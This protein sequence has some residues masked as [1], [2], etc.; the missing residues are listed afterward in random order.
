MTSFVPLPQDS[1]TES[2]NQSLEEQRAELVESL[3]TIIEQG[4]GMD[5]AEAIA[6]TE[7]LQEI[8]R[9]I[10][11]QE[12]AA[13]LTADLSTFMR[14]SW[15]IVE[16][17]TPLV[18]NWHY[19][20]MC[21][22]LTLVSS[23]EFK[24]RH[25]EKLGII[26]NVPPRTGKSTFSSVIWPV[27]TWLQ[28][29]ARRFL[30]ASHS[31]TLAENH[32]NKRAWLLKSLYFKER[33]ADRFKLVTCAGD[34]IRNDKTGQ[35]HVTSVGAG[36][37]G[38]GGMILVGDDL[39]DREKAFSK[40][41]KAKAN[42]WI[43][44]SFSK[45]LDDQVRGVT[46]HISQ[47]LAVDDPTGHLLGEDKRTG[48]PDHWIRIKIAREAVE[49]ELYVF[50]ISGQRYVRPKGDILQGKD[51]CPPLV[52]TRLKSKAREWANQEQQEPTPDTGAIINPNWMR[53]YRAGDTLP[54]FFRVIESIDCTFKAGDGTDMVAIHKYGLT[55]K[56][57]VLLDRR[58]ER[59]NYPS[60]KQAA[61]EMG[62]GGQKVGWLKDPMPPANLLLVENKA[63][64]PAL[65]DELRDDPEFSLTIIEYEPG[66]SSKTE[67]F[68][69]ASSDVEAG[70]CYFPID[71]PW[72]GELRKVLTEYA[73]E[74]SVAFDDDCDAF[75][76]LVNW[77]RQMQYGYLGYLDKQ[78]EEAAKGQQP[79][80]R[81]EY[82]IEP[83]R[84]IDL[85]WDPKREVWVGPD[86]Q[87]FS[88]G[89]NDNEV[90]S[91]SISGPGADST[92]TA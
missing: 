13:G 28:Y 38:F 9:Q 2:R 88:E 73:G 31:D 68:V 84:F 69:A 77:S 6:L 51:R 55:G 91:S 16:P 10:D 33:F 34:M 72:I 59:L 26:I 25:P 40:V 29:P 83:G 4:D 85:E 89:G 35:F 81:C 14:Q 12:I 75:S 76:Q 27:W 48:S 74:G 45:M 64:G 80:H 54:S 79:I 46:V 21:E 30:F 37:T 57:R 66:R 65:T 44:S 87:E 61:K 62:R 19:E 67:R 22:W 92:D 47:R 56:R 42:S 78:A 8:E 63:N 53:W 24:V 58:T 90:D 70:L 15:N 49:E 36:S 41:A 5:P 82:E 86:G 20:Y 18:W 1:E 60:T 43:D 3:E 52:L 39:L 11:M 17:E 32:N 50:P 71:A 23:G 7:R